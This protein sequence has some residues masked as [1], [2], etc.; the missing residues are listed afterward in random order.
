MSRLVAWSRAGAAWALLLAA[1]VVL[2]AGGQVLNWP[3]ERPPR[4]LPAREVRFPPYEVRT[5]ANGLQVVAVAHHEQ[6]AITLRLLVRAGAAH[7][8]DGKSGLAG[9]VANL[10]DQGTLTRSA[11]QIADAIDA[12]GGVLGTASSADYTLVTAV[13]MKDSFDFGMD[14]VSD[15]VR[16]PSFAPEE[17]ERQKERVVSSL[18]VNQTDPDYTASVLID[19]LVYG[20]HPYGFPGSG[21]PESLDGI[22]R[23]DLQAFHRRHFAPNNAILGIVGDVTT[24]EAFAVAEKVFGPW[25]RAEVPPFAPTDPPPSTRRVVVVDMPGA[26]QTEIRIGQIAIPRKHPDYVAFDLAAKILGGEG[27]NRL[28]RVLRS[29]RGLTYG[30]SAET[31]AMKHAG[32][33]VAETDTRTE[34]TGE[35]LRLAVDEFARLQRQRV[36]ERE[37]A[38]A[39]AYLAGSFPLT[40]ETPNQIATQVLNAVFYE[41]PLEEIAT[42]RERVLAV[43]PDDVLRVAQRY[44]RPDRLSIVLVGNAGAFAPQ[45]QGVGFG[46]FDLIPASQLDLTSATLRRRPERVAGAPVRGAAG[47]AGA[48][49]A[50]SRP[51]ARPGV[52]AAYLAPRAESGRAAADAG[53]MAALTRAVDALGGAGALRAVRT[54][55]AEAETIMHLPLPQPPVSSRTKTYIAY[56]DRFRVEGVLE[57]G[58]TI[59]VYAAGHAWVRSPAGVQV[60]S[61]PML[62]D[63]VASVRRDLIPLLLGAVDGRMAA[64]LLPAAQE[65]GGADG[66]VLELS[67]PGLRSVRLSL[68]AEGKVVRLSYV[69]EGPR[70][71]LLRAE[72]SF[73]DY[74]DVDGVRLPFAGQVLHNGRLV[75]ERRLTAVTLNPPLDAMLFEQPR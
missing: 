7:D 46:D 63:V 43:T 3:S 64:R 42:Y 6:P 16:N 41:L 70:G 4:P 52:R 14:L 71:V 2:P 40:I 60:V 26:V 1:L 18:Q 21:T 62:D 74:R 73:S 31:Q 10:L 5:L 67:G 22:T 33:L 45:L 19:R 37:L 34:T 28:H 17:I 25:P 69:V 65:A 8:P 55:V 23:A 9:L 68:D 35:V 51:P 61:G 29:E 39:Q 48:G 38:D 57:G 32:S 11:E 30:A 53:A 56:P 13:V 75:L 54:L 72:E 47:S 36:S 15:L 58:E 49:P 24:G 44:I 59:Q 20:F 27:A 66:T 50:S 12:V